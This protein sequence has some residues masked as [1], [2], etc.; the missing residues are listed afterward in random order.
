M[1]YILVVMVAMLAL[2]GV[3]SAG[4]VSSVMDFSSVGMV[5]THSTYSNTTCNSINAVSTSAFGRADLLYSNTVYGEGL[6]NSITSNAGRVG[7]TSSMMAYAWDVGDNTCGASQSCAGTPAY[8]RLVTASSNVMLN[9]AGYVDT[10]AMPNAFDL[11]A[12]GNGRIS[13]H[14]GVGDLNGYINSVPGSCNI[15][16]L[17]FSEHTNIVGSFNLTSRFTYN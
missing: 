1:R 16:E 14:V 4:T 5:S 2:G 6:T 11:N 17:D 10:N 12:A 15:N 7:A 9:G 13:R 3:A 8:S